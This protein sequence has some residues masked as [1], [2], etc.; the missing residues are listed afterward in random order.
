MHEIEELA[1]LWDFDDPVGSEERIRGFLAVDHSEIGVIE[2]K[3]QL[4]RALGLQKKFADAEALLAEVEPEVKPRSR[5]EIRWL[6]ERGRVFNSSGNPSES[7]PYFE[8]AWKTGLEIGEEAL[9]VDAAHM[10]AIVAP[11]EEQIEWNEKALELARHSKDP[12]AQQ[13]RSSLLNNLAW[14]YYDQT[15]FDQALALFEEAHELRVAQGKP[16]LERIA[17]YCKGKCLRAM[18]RLDEAMA[19]QLSVIHDAGEVGTAGF[20]EEEV[21]E[22]LLLLDRP[23]EARGFF[24]KALE[25]FEG[26]GALDDEPDRLARVKELASVRP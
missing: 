1:G 2:G 18:G 11:S 24:G 25:R 5:Q 26:N 7:R 3:T 19:I 14:T 17:R 16:V 20:P 12:K 23:E 9:A 21:G 6:L 13:W 15:S 4:A 10:V 22:C 8:K